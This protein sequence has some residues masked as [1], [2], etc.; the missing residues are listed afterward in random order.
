M[1][2]EHCLLGVVA[3][4]LVI[5]GCSRA[6]A[7]NEATNGEKGREVEL[8]IYSQNFAMVRDVR[9][10]DLKKGA[11]H[12]AI[13]GV[14]K[15]L[16]QN[17]VI[18]SFPK[19][20]SAKVTSTTYDLGT[21][22]GSQLL[23][24]F[25]GKQIDLVYRG[26]D[27]KEGARESGVLQVADPGNI[28]VKVGERLVVNPKAT[29]EAPADAGIVTIPQLSA[30]VESDADTSSPLSVNYMTQ[31]LSWSADYTATLESDKPEMHMECWATVTNT[32][33]ADFPDATIRFVAGSPNR[34]SENRAK[35]PRFLDAEQHVYLGSPSRMPGESPSPQEMGEL[36]AYP[37]S[38]KATVVQNQMNR[39]RMMESSS[40]KIAKFYAVSVPP[41][42]KE[43]DNLSGN[44]ERRISAT[45]GIN[46]TNGKSEGLG[47]PLPA[48]AVRFYE[49]DSKGVIRYMGAAAILDT[50]KDARASFTLSNVFNVYGRAK[51][52]A[53]KQIDKRHVS[54]TVEI[55]LNNEKA[56]PVEVRVVQPF[57]ENWKISNQSHPG[58]KLNAGSNQWTL[59]VPAGGEAKLTYTVILG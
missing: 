55:K 54:R 44:P 38:S 48:G 17:S 30:S 33:G 36:Y 10:V 26:D 23:Q 40:V 14:S 53:G 15:V 21:S 28:V 37:Y 32:T 4:V 59:E 56:N 41:L 19:V 18:Y 29:I 58:A 47:N 9:Q 35:S 25:L 31:G 7:Q 50:P 11:T 42:M 51:Q 45:L 39:V 20:A 43:Y 5:S 16:D 12:I 52:V 34:L 46:L 6:V 3:A 49:P 27:G 22:D 2:L 8:V 1:K 57:G 24:R 13:Q